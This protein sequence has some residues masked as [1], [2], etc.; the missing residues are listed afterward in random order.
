MKKYN[1]KIINENPFFDCLN[2]DTQI[3]YTTGV[4][5]RK[6][7]TDFVK[8]QI[9]NNASFSLAICDLDNMKNINDNFGHYYGDIALKAYAELLVKATEDCGVVGRFGGDEFLVYIESINENDYDELWLKLKSIVVM[10]S[11]LKL[12]K[13]LN[14]LVMTQTV[15][16]VR[17]PLDAISYD[18]LFFKLEKALFR[19]KQKG[20]NCFIIYLDHL[21]KNIDV[22]RSSP[23]VTASRVLEC[24]GKIVNNDNLTYNERIYGIFSIISNEYN[25]DHLAININ[26]KLENEYLKN[27]NKNKYSYISNDDFRI[28]MKNHMYYTNNYSTYKDKSPIAHQALFEQNVKAIFTYELICYGKFLGICRIED[29]SLK[30]VW[31][32]D[33]IS[34]YITL[35]NIIAI[36]K[37]WDVKDKN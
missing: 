4:L 2:Y 22:I 29:S 27:G 13:P 33:E 26:G 30:R 12:K 10:L 25:I 35:A 28:M 16:A 6:T 19:G 8:N 21:H 14:K 9:N 11:E 20:R 18:S 36:L 34:C 17:F 24:V 37:Y 5:D 7:I 23:K 15:G 1:C 32:E 3:D 31:Q